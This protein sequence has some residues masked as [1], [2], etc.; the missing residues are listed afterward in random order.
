MHGRIQWRR[1]RSG[2]LDTPGK[3]LSYQ[4]SHQRHASKTPFRWRAD[5]GPLIVYLDLLSAHQLET[6]PKTI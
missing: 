3:S 5:D 6:T 2:G 4:A 1:E